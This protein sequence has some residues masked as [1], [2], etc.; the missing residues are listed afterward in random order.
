MRVERVVVE[1][2]PARDGDA[3]PETHQG[4]EIRSDFAFLASDFHFARASTSTYERV[5]LKRRKKQRRLGR[6]ES[7]GAARSADVSQASKQHSLRENVRCRPGAAAGGLGEL[8]G[9]IIRRPQITF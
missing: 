6:L 8:R 1:H 7:S 2:H 5:L 4:T 9:F 3:D